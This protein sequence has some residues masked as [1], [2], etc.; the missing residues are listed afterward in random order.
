M[1]RKKTIIVMVVMAVMVAMV[2]MN[3]RK[4]TVPKMYMFGFAASFNDSIVHFTDIQQLDSVWIDTKYSFLE[5][6]QAY[7]YQLRDYLALHQ[8]LPNRTCIV[9]YEQ[10][11]SKLEKQYQKMRKLYAKGKDG[12]VHYDVR[13]VDAAFHFYTI[14]LS[15]YYTDNSAPSD[16]TSHH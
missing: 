10:D 16:T 7:S 1:N 12:L 2:S 5:E 4:V 13:Q 14:D 3:A 9:F 11:R 8:Q 15:Q 6:R